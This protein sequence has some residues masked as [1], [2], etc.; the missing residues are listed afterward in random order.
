MKLH[1]CLDG[2]DRLQRD[3]LD[4]PTHAPRKCLEGRGGLD[5][6]VGMLAD[7]GDGRVVVRGA[8]AAGAIGDY[9]DRL[10]ELAQV[11]DAWGHVRRVLSGGIGGV[12]GHACACSRFL[13]GVAKLGCWCCGLVAVREGGERGR[14]RVR[15]VSCRNNAAP[16]HIHINPLWLGVN[17]CLLTGS[18]GPG[19]CGGRAG[20]LVR[21]CQ[22]KLG[23]S[24][25]SLWLVNVDKEQ[26]H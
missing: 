6:L 8:A 4:K 23:I 7:G 22:I 15:Q 13:E 1:S 5:L 21:G 20:F 3:R 24:M 14:G 19:L 16:A 25:R 26:A 10:L 2:I 11:P 18:Q 9:I 12:G 17:R